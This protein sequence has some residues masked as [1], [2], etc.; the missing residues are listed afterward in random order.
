[1]QIARDLARFR[2]GAA[3]GS[4]RAGVA[5]AFRG[6]IES[7]ASVVH[8]ATGPEQLAIWADVDAASLVP[9]EVRAREDA[10]LTVALLPDRN[11][12]RYLLLLDEPTEEL[13]RPVSA[14]GGSRFGFR[15]KQMSV[16]SSIVL[17]AATSSYA[18]AGVASTSTITAVSMSMR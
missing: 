5:V 7:S 1:V 6:T 12:R 18:R 16:R 15:P 13:A 11:V 17:V 14:V 2:S 3:F 4:Q 9:P 8:C 10:V